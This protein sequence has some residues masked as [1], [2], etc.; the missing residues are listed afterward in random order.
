[1][2][3]KNKQGSQHAQWTLNKHST[4][5]L[6]DER[7]VSGAQNIICLKC[8]LGNLTKAAKSRPNR[9]SCPDGHFYGLQSKI[10][11]ELYSEP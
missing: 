9:L 5:P 1:M 2:T 10:L 8:Q 3:V 6:Q 11:N 4:V 7:A